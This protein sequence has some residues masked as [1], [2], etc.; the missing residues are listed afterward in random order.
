VTISANSI[1]SWLYMLGG[2]T[3]DQSF[4]FPRALGSVEAAAIHVAN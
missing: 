4:T 2:I 1:G 3:L